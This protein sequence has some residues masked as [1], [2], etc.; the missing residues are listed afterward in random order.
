LLIA[1]RFVEGATTEAV[2]VSP[3][4][5]AMQLAA[6]TFGFQNDYL[7][8]LDVIA[9]LCERTACF[10]L[11]IGDLATAVSLIDSLVDEQ[12]LSA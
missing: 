3:G 1:P 12:R 10:N 11:T 8:S 5:M 6:C 7:R 2:Q 4:Q 9:R